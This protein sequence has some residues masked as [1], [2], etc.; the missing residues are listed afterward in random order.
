MFDDRYGCPSVV[1]IWHCS[2]CDHFFCVPPLEAKEIAA[3]YEQFYGRS[4][5]QT[6]D[7]ERTARASVAAPKWKRW[8]KGETNSG[9]HLA[10]LPS[11]LLD[12][13]S[14]ACQDV[15]EAKLLGH[16]AHGFDVDSTSARLG[17]ELG[18]DVR[19]G[20][21]VGGAFGGDRFEWIQLNQV[22]EHY[23]DPC[24]SV[25]AVT[26]L[27][28][29]GGRLFVA[30]PNASSLLRRAT[31]RRWINWHVPYHQQHFT[32]RSLALVLEGCGLHVET[33]RT[34][35]P[36]VWFL[37]QVRSMFVAPSSGQPTETWTTREPSRGYKEFTL[38][39]M[40]LVALLGAGA[41]SRILDALK[42]GE[43]LVVVAKKPM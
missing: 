25:Q 15:L 19:S 39:V 4:R 18:V 3:L 43:S 36:S 27:L 22:I 20:D 28:S 7:I 41:I 34:V 16:D 10:P 13:G 32:R 11:H 12:I 6:E 17:R 40:L 37:L 26:D 14:G 35:T 23:V 24:S 29:P 1:D 8:Y 5:V 2:D 21:D 38:R 31:R 33:V 30:T 9:Q 42:V